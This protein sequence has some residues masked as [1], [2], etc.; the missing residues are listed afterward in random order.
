MRSTISLALAAAVAACA[1]RPASSTANVLP[2]PARSNAPAESDFG[3]L[4]MAHGGTD[5]WNRAVSDAVAPLQERELIEVAFGMAD[6]RTLQDAVSRLESRGARRIGVVRLFISGDSWHE[7]TRQIL[8]LIPGAPE[9]PAD[10]AQ[11][12]HHHGR[13]PMAYWRL[14]SDASF[15]VSRDGLADAELAGQILVDRVRKLSRHPGREAVIIIA[16]GPGDDRENE[17]WISEIDARAAA[18][19][20][21][22]PLQRVAVMTLREDWPDKRA[23]AEQ[24]IRSFVKSNR[25]AG[26]T[27]IVVPFRL[28][29]FGPY[30]RVLQG[31]DY[32][33]DSTGLM[34]HPGVTRWVESQIAELRRGPFR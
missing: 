16:H 33:A 19:R 20:E 24:R 17:R 23:D 7:R 15:A 22:L 21:A 3:V 8:G 14:K 11:G 1:V 26:S 12:T 9:R 27:T 10:W 5:Q 18:V 30:A 2:T 6:P 25:Q 32:V 29:G 13:A 4:V 28:F 34:P 31:L